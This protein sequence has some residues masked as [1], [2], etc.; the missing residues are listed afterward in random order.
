MLK[1][2]HPVGQ[3]EVKQHDSKYA[4]VMFY[5]ALEEFGKALKLQKAKEK[6]TMNQEQYVEDSSLFVK[7]D[8]KVD[9]SLKQYP[10][11]TIPNWIQEQIKENTYKL[12][13][14]GEII[15]DFIERSNMWL[16]SYDQNSNKWKEQFFNI[17][18]EIVE[19]KIDYLDK[20]LDEWQK[21]Y[22][23]ISLNPKSWY[24]YNS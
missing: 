16:V 19:T 6:T 9:E 1:D 21:K 18:D 13:P 14:N 8:Y 2:W 24:K 5:Y 3:F 22:G 23:K 12:V 11:L 10:D 7:H 17:D 15:E 4:I 20:L